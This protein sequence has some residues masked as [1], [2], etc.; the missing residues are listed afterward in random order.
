MEMKNS[1]LFIFVVLLLCA[2]G[3]SK[4]EKADE[5]IHKYLLEEL[6]DYES[7]TPIESQF[8]EA[9]NVALNDSNCHKIAMRI[10]KLFSEYDLTKSV[11]GV[12]LENVGLL[13]KGEM[14]PENWVSGLDRYPEISQTQ[15]QLYDIDSKLTFEISKLQINRLSEGEKHIGYSVTHKFRYKDSFGNPAAGNYYFLFDKGL[16]NIVCAINLNDKTNKAMIEVIKQFCS[17][18]EQYGG[19]KE[20]QD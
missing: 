6:Y 20:L 3:K 16:N 19:Q 11:F 7:Y 5:L 2:C 4:E 12:Q 10:V 13:K 8:E 18:D 1:I 14:I 15:K 17:N 9:Y